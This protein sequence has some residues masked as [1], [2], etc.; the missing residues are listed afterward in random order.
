METYVC[1]QWPYSG[2]VKLIQLAANCGN[3]H[4]DYE[5]V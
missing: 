1:P 4:D 2:T 5:S 3:Q